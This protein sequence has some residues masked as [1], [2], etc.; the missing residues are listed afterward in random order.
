MALGESAT[1]RLSYLAWSGGD[2]AGQM[3]Q[4]VAGLA[5]AALKGA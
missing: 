3:A 1:L 2:L 5:G 4:A